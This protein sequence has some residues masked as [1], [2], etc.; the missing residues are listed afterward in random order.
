MVGFDASFKTEDY[1]YESHWCA[2]LE[3]GAQLHYDA[4]GD[5]W[6][7]QYN[8]LLLISVEWGW[9]LAG[10]AKK[11]IKN[12]K[13]REKVNHSV[14]Q[15]ENLLI[16][17][18]EFYI[19]HKKYVV[20][21]SSISN[22]FRLIISVQKQPFRDVLRKRCSGNMQQIYR[23][24]PMPKCD[25]ISRLCS[26]KFFKGCLPQILLGPLLNTLPQACNF[27]KKETL[28]QVFSHEFC[29]ISKNTFF[30]EHL[31]TTASDFHDKFITLYYTCYTFQ[32]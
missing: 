1:R 19:L 21:P 27:I 26:F 23:R 14:I 22:I 20:H 8:M 24:T 4:T 31:W 9:L 28:K 7:K 12:Q 2:R 16:D 25:F 32:C 3:F 30:I 10:V 17:T 11:L 6:V 15:Q 18:K 5:L 29:E 13:S